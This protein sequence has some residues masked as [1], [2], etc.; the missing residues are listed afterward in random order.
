VDPILTVAVFGV[1]A[2][3]LGFWA[4]VRFPTLGPQRVP[5]ALLVAAFAFVSQT[6]V[7]G[8]VDPVRLALGIPGAFL[9]VVLPSLTTLF[10]ATGCLVRSLVALA[11][12]YRP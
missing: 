8:L 9:L 2:A 7:L 1:G 6:P 12:P 11:A 10:W 5:A 3:M 4:V